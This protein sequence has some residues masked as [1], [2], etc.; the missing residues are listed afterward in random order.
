MKGFTEKSMIKISVL[1]LTCLQILAGTSMAATVSTT[2]RVPNYFSASDNSVNTTEFF[3]IPSDGGETNYTYQVNSTGEWKNL[4]NLEDFDP[5]NLGSE[6]TVK[7]RANDT[8]GS[9]NYDINTTSSI[10][11]D[12][13]KPELRGA[14]RWNDDDSHVR[15]EIVVDIVDDVSGVDDSTVSDSNLEI[16]PGQIDR[17]DVGDFILMEDTVDAKYVD[18]NIKGSIQDKAGNKLSSGTVTACCMGKKPV[19]ENPTIDTEGPITSGDEVSV[20]AVVTDNVEVDNVSVEAQELGREKVWM[21]DEN[22][23]NNF[24]AEFT[25]SPE[26]ELSGDGSKKLSVVANDTNSNENST[27]TGSI[28]LDTTAPSID[29]SG[30]VNRNGSNE[31]TDVGDKIVVKLNVSDQTTVSSVSGNASEFNSTLE[32]SESG[33]ASD[34]KGVFEVA[35]PSNDGEKSVKINLEDSLG[36]SRTVS[37]DAVGVDNTPPVVSEAE[38]GYNDGLPDTRD[39]IMI[40]FDDETSG[41]ET[42]EINRSVFK[43]ENKSIDSMDIDRQFQN[44]ENV[45]RVYIELKEDLDTNS[46]PEIEFN[47]SLQDKAGN[48]FVES[49]FEAID[50]L[51]PYPVAGA[52]FD[53]DKDGRVDQIKVNITEN[54]TYENPEQTHWSLDD[55]NMNLDMQEWQVKGNQII[56]LT[57]GNQ[58]HTGS[59]RDVTLEYEEYYNGNLQ[60]LNG[61]N[62]SNTEIRLEDRADPVISFNK[63]IN[64]VSLPSRSGE[65]SIESL[66]NSEE[67]SN[68]SDIK[69]IWRYADGE[70]QT[71]VPGRISNEF[72]EM[73]SGEGYL[74]KS[75]DS[76]KIVADIDQPVKQDEKPSGQTIHKERWN[77]IGNYG[78][79]SIEL[80]RTAMNQLF[81]LERNSGAIKSVLTE[82]EDGAY[83]QSL[84]MASGKAYW[85]SSAEDTLYTPLYNEGGLRPRP[86]PPLGDPSF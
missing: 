79:G 42:K 4:T 18:V 71:Y 39:D 55:G 58:G 63:G 86:E 51:R 70:W 33:E 44:T 21:Y 13:E 49:S 81:T 50:G 77:L 26:S 25:V 14:S 16:T 65:Y 75:K 15:T 57:E 20:S 78:E 6:A 52:F 43:I 17:V 2:D 31:W 61:N 73:E 60:D 56:I 5:T 59:R 68:V 80:R 74:I 66:L 83:R 36:N 54:I 47:R 53:N 46:I 85:V 24:T 84:E 10:T 29:S 23:D 38:T 11:V 19:I 1:F 48:K 45:V 32:L 12:T 9:G 62:P 72:T 69:S 37:L 82:T 22:N 64:L 27:N 30:Q 67:N 40:E 34:Y 76:G 41:L 28:L 7:F 35:E 3:S 8:D